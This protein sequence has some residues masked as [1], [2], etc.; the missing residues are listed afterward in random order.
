M[1]VAQR[2]P[3]AVLANTDELRGFPGPGRARDAA[4][5]VPASIG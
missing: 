4:R 2:I 3:R 1:Q 5:L